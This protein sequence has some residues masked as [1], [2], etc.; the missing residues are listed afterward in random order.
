VEPS[1][2]V[3]LAVCG[4]GL[5]SVCKLDKGRG[6]QVRV[7]SLGQSSGGTSVALSFRAP[8]DEVLS[9]A[10]L[11]S[12]GETLACGTGSGK[13]LIFNISTKGMELSQRV[14]Q[15]GISSV[16]KLQWNRD[17]NLLAVFEFRH[18]SR[19]KGGDLR[20]WVCEDLCTT[21]GRLQRCRP[22]RWQRV[23]PPRSRSHEGVSSAGREFLSIC[24]ACW[25]EDSMLLL[26]RGGSASV[27]IRVPNAS[28]C[29]WSQS[30][31][32][33]RTSAPFPFP[34]KGSSMVASLSS[35]DET[36]KGAVL[37]AGESAILDLH[38]PLLW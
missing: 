28:D 2:C 9:A 24:D 27:H 33:P 8:D 4:G 34:S 6:A 16:E 18:G 37:I 30:T 26:H 22:P 20:V 23:L 17:L 38:T 35:E 29:A 31:W 3:A 21:E 15:P 1:P 32:I 7:R 25:H 13:V 12:R 36:G 10:W 14:S 5:A 19:A 11:H